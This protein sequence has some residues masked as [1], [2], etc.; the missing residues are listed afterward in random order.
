V[1]LYFRC[2]T[3]PSQLLGSYS[4]VRSLYDDGA[5]EAKAVTRDY[6]LE[7]DEAPGPKLLS[8]FGGKITTARALAEEA[9]ALLG[10][11]GGK[12]T[13]SAQFPTGDQGPS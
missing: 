6:H 2:Q 7:L 13:A 4:G 11:Q 8:I 10:I 1:N 12:W 5:G 9:V 3:A